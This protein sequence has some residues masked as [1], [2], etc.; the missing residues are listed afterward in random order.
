[1]HRNSLLLWSALVAT[2]VA[3]TGVAHA[4]DD[5]AAIIVFAR[6]GTDANLAVRIERD[7][8]NLMAVQAVKDPN[9]PRLK[10]IEKRFDVGNLSKG[11]LSRS[12]R[13][14]NSAQRAIS[15]KDYEKAKGH[16]FRARRFYNR[17]SPHALTPRC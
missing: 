9:T 10:A 15:K 7:L 8:R 1:M 4:Q 2:F 5:K 16:L 13:Q 11:H 17:A 6:G 3:F 14:F 12:R